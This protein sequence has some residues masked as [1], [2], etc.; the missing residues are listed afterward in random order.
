MECN[1]CINCMAPVSV[2]ICPKCGFD[3]KSYKPSQDTLPAET[4]LYGRYF[5]G[6]SAGKSRTVKKY[7]G[8][9]LKERKKVVIN[10]YYPAGMISRRSGS[11]TVECPDKARAA[12]EKGKKQFAAE[13]GAA[14]FEENGTVYSAVPALNT[15]D[16]AESVRKKRNIILA[17]IISALVITAAA[18][19]CV[20]IFTRNA[21]PEKP[22][23]IPSVTNSSA[24]NTGSGDNGKG[25]NGGG[26]IRLK[27][28]TAEEFFEYTEDALYVTITKYTGPDTEVFIP[29][30]INGRTV[31]AIGDSAFEGASHVT[32]IEMPEG[33]VSVG[34]RAFANCS[35]MTEIYIPANV[36]SIGKLAFYGC[37]SLSALKL[38]ITNNQYLCIDGLL[39]NRYSTK[40]IVCPAGYDKSTYTIPDSVTEVEFGAFY[41]CT[42]LNEVVLSQK[43]E[44]IA[45]YMF[46]NCSGLKSIDLPDSV[47]SIGRWSFFGCKD[48]LEITISK[49]VTFI[50]GYA[51]AGCSGLA[52]INVDLN[53]TKYLSDNG[54]LMS[55]DKKELIA[56]PGGKGQ[57]YKIPPGVE[58]IAEGAF[59]YC[60]GLR[61]VTVSDGVKTIGYK[62]FTECPHLEEIIIPDSVSSIGEYAFSHCTELGT[63]SVPA[64]CKVADTAFE[65]CPKAAVVYR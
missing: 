57:T 27:I 48:L 35:S 63:V 9:D 44:G 32:C 25:S 21:P 54:V 51:F 8:L 60:D 47:T 58:T 52:N 50:N 40:L 38:S 3:R 23:T 56:Y 64:G 17:A 6:R 39:Y 4:V 7:A 41:G 46:Y 11:L 24:T 45:D 29:E 36:Q 31:T 26:T 22:D 13:A 55:A 37:D 18:L 19:I 28:D 62:S 10:E 12:F 14:V 15:V 61:S 42:A 65:D 2:E 59:S 49:N 30:R 33:V 16:T 1:F 20:F 34:Y 53:N 5:V 43:L